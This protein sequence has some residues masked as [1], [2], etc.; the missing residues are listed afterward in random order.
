MEITL[1]RRHIAAILFI[2]TGL[3]FF[4]DGMKGYYNVK[5]AI[6]LENLTTDNI[7]KG[8]YVKGIVTEYAGFAPASLG[9]GTFRG[10]SVTFLG[11]G[12]SDIDFY[13]IRIKDG[14]YITLMVS[15]TGTKNL[16]EEYDNG[17]GN[18][19]YI[20]G[21]IT[22]PA[23]ELNYNWLQTALGKSSREEVEEL[24]SAQYAIK[25][26]DFSKKGMGMLYALGCIVTAAILFFSDRPEK[27]GMEEKE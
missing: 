25:E 18:S 20:E 2:I 6:S 5:T 9:Q 24:V 26:T 12:F 8:R 11:G 3:V 15:D 13:T 27:T 22:S 14:R 19:V 21:E 4:A 1:N 23:T 10:V 17:I 7:Q 16:L